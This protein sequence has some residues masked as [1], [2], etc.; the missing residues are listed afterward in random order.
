MTWGLG[1][2]VGH[3]VPHRCTECFRRP[4]RRRHRRVTL[5]YALRSVE[6]E[7]PRHSDATVLR[8]LSCCAWSVCW[9]S[10]QTGDVFNLFVFLEISSLSSYALISMGQRRRALT[11]AYQYLIMGTIGATFLLIGIG[12][13]YAETGT[14]NMLDLQPRLAD[15]RFEHRTVHTGFAFIVVGIALKLA[16]F[17]LHLWLPNAYTVRAD[18]RIGVPGRHR[19]QGRG[20]HHAAHGLHR[21]L[22]QFQSRNTHA[23]GLP[24]PGRGRCT[25][26]LVWQPSINRTPSACWPIPSIGQIG[27]WSWASA[28]ASALGLTA[29]SCI[30]STTP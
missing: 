30:Y 11:A 27:T 6:Q 9:V 1:A 29:T 3:R 18:R 10:V 25:G 7:I 16:L 12:L 17:P 15:R 19:H 2:A 22:Q 13:I 4:D 8:R 24:D 23:G 28:S 26:G 21:F 14:L 5:P 20:L